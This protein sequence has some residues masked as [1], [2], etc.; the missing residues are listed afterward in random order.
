MPPRQRRAN[1]RELER[2]GYTWCCGTQL[3]VGLLQQL[4]V[5]RLRRGEATLQVCAHEGD[6]R[7][8]ALV[9]AGSRSDVGN[10]PTGL[11]DHFCRSL[12]GPGVMAHVRG[13]CRWCCGCG[14]QVGGSRAG[15][16]S[17][18][19]S[20]VSFREWTGSPLSRRRLREWVSS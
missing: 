6:P 5:S 16:G 18:R 9:G 2:S 15:A 10:R 14:S 12:A 13:R 19:S 1:Y 4:I 8:F 20:L 11:L 3:V 17:V 7:P